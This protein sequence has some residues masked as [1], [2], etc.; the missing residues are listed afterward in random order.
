MKKIVIASQNKHKIQEINSILRDFN[1][2][3]VSMA[4]AGL[5]DVDILEDGKSFE[6]NSLKKAR[7]ICKLTDMITIGDDSGLEVD[8]LDLKPGIYS[9][10]FAGENATDDENNQKLIHLMKDVPLAERSARY[11]C[12]ITMVFPD[13]KEL[14]ARGEIEGYISTFAEGDKGFGY[15]PYF[16]PNGYERSFG[17]FEP[18]EKN[19]I[20]HR[21]K[22]LEALRKLIEKRECSE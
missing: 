13:G 15:D 3:G 11:V 9:A 16:I 7:E 19:K 18:E 12:V 4:E 21:G 2:I 14:V 10:R 6:E 17:C 1:M 20:S 8:C 5:V 22:A